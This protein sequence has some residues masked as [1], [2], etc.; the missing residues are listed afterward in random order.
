MTGQFQSTKS[1]APSSREAPSPKHTAQDFGACPARALLLSKGDAGARAFW[2]APP[3]R[4]GFCGSRRDEQ[5]SV[6]SPPEAIQ[7][8]VAA[9]LCRRTPKRRTCW[10]CSVRNNTVCERAAFWSAAGSEAPR[11]FPFVGSSF[12][13]NRGVRRGLSRCWET[14]TNKTFGDLKFGISLE[15]GAWSL[16]LDSSGSASRFSTLWPELRDSGLWA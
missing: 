13:S 5:R 9:A 15:L 6:V 11:R 4:F 3:S 16:E 10:R 7:S 1:Q 2:S 12:I 8:A 14:D